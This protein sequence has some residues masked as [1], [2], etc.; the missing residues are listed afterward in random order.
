MKETDLFPKQVL[1]VILAGV[2]QFCF[3]RLGRSL[4]K[5]ECSASAL[6]SG[7]LLGS[8]ALIAPVT[9]RG[10]IRAPFPKRQARPTPPARP[11]LAGGELPRPLHV[12]VAGAAVAAAVASA[13][14]LLFRRGGKLLGGFRVVAVNSAAVIL[15]EASALAYWSYSTEKRYEAEKARQEADYE[16]EKA[17]REA[18]YEAQR[19][20]YR[21]RGPVRRP[22]PVDSP[23][24]KAVSAPI[25]P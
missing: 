19:R 24:S 13:G 23:V 16:A 5:W 3:G 8:L 14:V 12:V 15:T 10:D 9:V 22:E 21:G 2:G 20:G 4:S 17:R 25:Q 7:Q 1:H 6:I 18:A 11:T